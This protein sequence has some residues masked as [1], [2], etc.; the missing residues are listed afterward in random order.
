MLGV[1]VS[2]QKNPATVS[3]QSGTLKS[4][5]ANGLP[6]QST[7][8]VVQYQVNVILRSD[9]DPCGAYL[10][11]VTNSS[12]AY[13]ASPQTWSPSKDKYLFTELGHSGMGIR[14]AKLIRVL[15]V[16]QEE[17]CPSQLWA[18]PDWKNLNLSD[19]IQ[20]SFSLSVNINTNN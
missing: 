11:A 10:V 6:V 12:G 13:V 5:I 4:T 18:T 2:G 8:A 3:S 17:F 15:P 20:Y 9:V 19:G 16:G 1:Y 7:K 14:I